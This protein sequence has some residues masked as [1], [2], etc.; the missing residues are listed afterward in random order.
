MSFLALDFLAA[1]DNKT[2]TA[3]PCFCNCN[4]KQW[5]RMIVFCWPWLIRFKCAMAWFSDWCSKCNAFAWMA[6]VAWHWFFM[7]LVALSMAIESDGLFSFVRTLFLTWSHMKNL[8]LKRYMGIF[9]IVLNHLRLTLPLLKQ[10]FCWFRREFSGWWQASATNICRRSLSKIICY[11][12]L[13]RHLSPRI[14]RRFRACMGNPARFCWI[15]CWIRRLSSSLGHGLYQASIFP[16]Q[17]F[18]ISKTYPIIR[19]GIFYKNTFDFT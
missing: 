4:C 9:Q 8:T 7:H 19:V 18:F 14:F 10:G 15:S 17:I 2:H 12:L 11:W 3:I 1:R 5:S 13:T 16:T 6:W